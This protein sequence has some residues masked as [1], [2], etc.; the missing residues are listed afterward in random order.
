MFI[1]H[2]FIKEVRHKPEGHLNSYVDN[3]QIKSWLKKTTNSQAK[4]HIH[5]IVNTIKRYVEYIS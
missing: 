5:N 1:E 3:K 4:A 2:I